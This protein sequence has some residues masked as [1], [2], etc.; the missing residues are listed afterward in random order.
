MRVLIIEDDRNKERH[1]TD[2]L[3]SEFPSASLRAR[4]SYQSGLAEAEGWLP[5]IIILDMSMPTYDVSP[6]ESGEPSL[7]FGG[8]DI[9]REVD[10]KGLACMVVVVT[11]Y[12]AFGTRDSIVTLEQ[13]KHRLAANYPHNY[14]GTVFYHPAQTGWRNEL[15]SN[16]TRLRSLEGR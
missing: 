1:L 8:E 11:Q 4:R 16:L 6:T 5:H 13:L 15:L 7:P 3:A 10:R 14:I 2:L 9:L 12:D